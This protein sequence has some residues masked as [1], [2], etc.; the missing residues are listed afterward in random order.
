MIRL[1]GLRI[2][3]LIPYLDIVASAWMY[4]TVQRWVTS[5]ELPEFLLN[6]RDGEQPSSEL[7]KCLESVRCVFH[8]SFCAECWSERVHPGSRDE[9]H[10]SFHHERNAVP[11]EGEL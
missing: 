5:F 4:M 3:L 6:F 9:F 1:L 8:H 10:A 11:G 2:L 7:R